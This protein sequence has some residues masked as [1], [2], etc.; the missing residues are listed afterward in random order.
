MVFRADHG[1]AA[2]RDQGL[3]ALQHG[4]Y[5]VNG[6]CYEAKAST[7]TMAR[8]NRRIG[9]LLLV[10]VESLV[11]LHRLALARQDFNAAGG[12]VAT[13][14]EVRDAGEFHGLDDLAGVL[15]VLVLGGPERARGCRR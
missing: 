9:C 15:A 2:L 13:E 3:G 1:E 4:N 12:G 14:E 7:A 8:R 11:Q 6:T 10:G 5:R